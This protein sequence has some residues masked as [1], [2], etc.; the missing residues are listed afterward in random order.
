AWTPPPAR[1]SQPRGRQRAWLTSPRRVA[2]AQ[3]SPIGPVFACRGQAWAG[4][5]SQMTSTHEPVALSADDLAGLADGFAAKPELKRMQNAVVRVG[6]AEVAL[7]HDV[8]TGL[9]HS[10]SNRLDDW[11]VTNQKNS[12]RCWLFAALN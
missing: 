6:I 2:A 7:D 5:V 10:V 8:V 3:R 11:K 1:Q 9:S 12:G 4:Y